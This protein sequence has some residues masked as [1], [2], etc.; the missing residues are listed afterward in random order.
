MPLGLALWLCLTAYL[1][2]LT[3]FSLVFPFGLFVSEEC[4]ET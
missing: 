1:D 4:G 2:E 3:D